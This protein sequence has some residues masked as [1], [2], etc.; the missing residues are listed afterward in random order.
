MSGGLERILAHIDRLGAPAAE[1]TRLRRLVP[2]LHTEKTRVYGELIAGGGA[3]LRPG[4][5]SLVAEGR[6]AGLAFGFAATSA[7]TNVAALLAAAF[8]GARAAPAAAIVCVDQVARKKPA[9]D[10]YELLLA[11]LRLPAA[12]CVAFEDSENGVRAAKAAGLFTVAAPS[13]WTA[14]QDLSGADLLLPSLAELRLEQL[15]AARGRPLLRA[16]R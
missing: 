12:A 1:K 6:A 7:S 3:C 5:A 4:V 9:P 11:T 2:A 13:R 10:L 15:D 16:V 14:L 8:G